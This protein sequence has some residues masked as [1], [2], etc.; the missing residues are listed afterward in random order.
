MIYTNMH[1][2]PLL[3]KGWIMLSNG[4]ITI[5]WISVSKTNH[6]INWI[7]IYQA[8]SLILLSNNPGQAF[9]YYQSHFSL[10]LPLHV[11]PWQFSSVTSAARFFS[12]FLF[13]HP[14]CK[15]ALGYRSPESLLLLRKH[16][17]FK[18]AVHFKY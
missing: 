11:M 13:Q 1:T 4:K 2:R 12:L 14:E 3:F 6:T 10:L 8:D 18:Y 7:V 5:Q 9:H 15:T 16:V 17:F